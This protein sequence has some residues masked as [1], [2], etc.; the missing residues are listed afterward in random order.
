MSSIEVETSPPAEVAPGGPSR[1]RFLAFALGAG[2]LAG[3]AAWGAG[4]ACYGRFLPPPMKAAG[5]PTPAEAAASASGH[6]RGII[7]EASIAR[8]LLGG[9]LGAALGAAGGLARR[10]P[11]ATA[12]AAALG[13]ALGATAAVIA[14][15]LTVPLAFR[16]QKPD[17]DDLLAAI[18]LQGSIAA[19][20]GAAAG[21]ALAIGS[22]LRPASRAVVAGLAGAVVGLVLYQVVG[23]LAFPLAATSDPVATTSPARLTYHLLVALLATV[24]AALSFDSPSRHA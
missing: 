1:P 13:A 15:R 2:L 23:A 19:A 17:G 4:E 5:I 22:G 9:L 16:Y 18:L 21:L 3:L 24:A 6:R 20:I 11:R 10:S 7:M 14:V 12:K 8:G